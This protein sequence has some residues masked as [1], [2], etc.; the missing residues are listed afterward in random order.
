M[1]L[2]RPALDVVGG[3][4]GRD[5]VGPGRGQVVRGSRQCVRCPDQ[6]SGRIGEN[7][8]VHAVML[9]LPRVVRAVGGDAV[10]RQERAVEDHVRLPADRFHGLLQR[11]SERG[12]EIDGLVYVAVDR[13]DPDVKPAAR[14]A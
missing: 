5:V 1:R 4:S 6:A 2:V 7:L 14:R 3:Q 13:R 11:R 10:D 8:H 12:Q 9:L